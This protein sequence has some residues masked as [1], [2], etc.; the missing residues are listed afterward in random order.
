MLKILTSRGATLMTTSSP[1]CW[2]CRLRIATIAARAL[3]SM[4]VTSARSMM[5][6][7]GSRSS[8]ALSHSS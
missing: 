3:L 7:S 1:P 4:K 5:K 2:R 8:I 6:E